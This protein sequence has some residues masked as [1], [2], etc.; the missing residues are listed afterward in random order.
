MTVS[1]TGSLNVFTFFVIF[2]KRDLKLNIRLSNVYV[3]FFNFPEERFRVKEINKE[4]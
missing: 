2:Q 3:F 1:D 4:I